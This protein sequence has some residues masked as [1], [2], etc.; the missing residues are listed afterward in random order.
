MAKWRNLYPFQRRYCSSRP[1]V[2]KGNCFI[3]V[4]IIVNTYVTDSVLKIVLNSAII[5]YKHKNKFVYCQTKYIDIFTV[6]FSRKIC[7]EWKNGQ[8]SHQSYTITSICMEYI[9]ICHEC[10]VKCSNSSFA[11][12]CFI[13]KF[14][15]HLI[16]INKCI[17]LNI[18]SRYH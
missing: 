3:L 6:F 2:H 17:F 16:K 18:N 11:M 12:W 10:Y 7:F 13:L 4:S 14:V 1:V 9:K 5:I 15:N 8:K